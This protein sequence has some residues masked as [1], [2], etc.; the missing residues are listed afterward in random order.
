MNEN[1]HHMLVVVEG[2]DQGHTYP[3]QGMIC[4]L[5]RAS[6]N[7]IVI[8][9]PRVSRHHAQ[10]RLL[11]SGAVIE[12]MGSTN[13]TWVNQRRVR[14]T[15]QLSSGDLISLA[16]FISFRYRIEGEPHTER[17][18]TPDEE[19]STQIMGD[20]LPVPDDYAKAH[21]YPTPEPGVGSDDVVFTPAYEPVTPDGTE[22]EDFA[23]TKDRRP[24]WVYILIGL[25]VLLICACVAFAVYL[26]FAPVEFWERVFDLF[27]I[28]MP[29]EGMILWVSTY[30][31]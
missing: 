21:D 5:G 27:G 16:D 11:P 8:D 30:G 14:G 1:K 17:F 10:I 25:L 15:H 3:L 7:T 24:T 26:W 31:C 28:P 12:D 2:S 6:D 13:G 4:T 23:E 29:T 18:G 20:D 19:S 9:S 22:D